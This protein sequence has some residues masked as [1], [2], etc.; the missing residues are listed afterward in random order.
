MFCSEATCLL[1]YYIYK[2]CNDLEVI[3]MELDGRK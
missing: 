3:G 2:K 1:L